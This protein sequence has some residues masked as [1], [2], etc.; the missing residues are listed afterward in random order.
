MRSRWS[1]T[2]RALS[3]LL[4]REWDPIGLYDGSLDEGSPDAPW[5]PGEYD[6]YAGWLFASLQRGGGKPEVLRLMSEAREAM[7]IGD[8]REHDDH[9]ADALLAWWN[10]RQTSWH[11]RSTRFRR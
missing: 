8:P 1:E 6:M 2:L 4:E 10:A 7:G 11:P 3:E 5:P 9:A